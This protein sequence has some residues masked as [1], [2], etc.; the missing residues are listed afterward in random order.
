MRRICRAVGWVYLVLCVL[1]LGLIPAT[2]AGLLEPNP[3]VALY[4]VLLGLPWSLLFAWL[5]PG[6]AGVAVSM[7]LIAI[8]M[9]VN[10]AL[11]RWLC[12]PR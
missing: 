1:A 8:G 10:L 12:R 4:A 7:A 2:G 9:A 11:L 3:F 6:D 5:T